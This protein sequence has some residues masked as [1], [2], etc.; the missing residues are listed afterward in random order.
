MKWKKL[1]SLKSWAHV[2]KRL[3]ALLMSS[4]V[5]LQDKLLFLVPAAVYWVM[6]DVLPL[7]PIDDIG[8]TMFLMNWF[9]QRAERKYPHVAGRK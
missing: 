1:L 9:V 4:E 6:P 3:P 8:V 5:Q 7:L 2:F